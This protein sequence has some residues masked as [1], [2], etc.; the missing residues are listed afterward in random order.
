MKEQVEIKAEMKADM[1]QINVQLMK[2]NASMEAI[3]AEHQ[4]IK[5]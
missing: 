3:T 2:I 5:P 1:K 4:K